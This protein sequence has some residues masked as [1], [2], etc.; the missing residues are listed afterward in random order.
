[1][2]LDVWLC[3]HGY[4]S[5]ALKHTGQVQLDFEEAVKINP[6]NLTALYNLGMLAYRKNQLD[7]ANSYLQKIIN[8]DTPDTPVEPG[9]LGLALRQDVLI[10]RELRLFTEAIPLAEKSTRVTPDRAD[11]WA[12]LSDLYLNTPLADEAKWSNAAAAAQKCIDRATR[13]PDMRYACHFNLGRAYLHMRDLDK[14]WQAYRE[15]LKISIPSV[16]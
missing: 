11:V 5:D 9:Q 2:Q 6:N 4:A 1:M 14:S 7:V 15:G 10:K 12:T 16:I 13:E 8:R 3:L